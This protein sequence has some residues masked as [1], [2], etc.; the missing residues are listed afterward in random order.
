ML[1]IIWIFRE[2]ADV[3]YALNNEAKYQFM[4]E[5]RNV[6]SAKENNSALL[7]STVLEDQD[8]TILLD[9]E[10]ANSTDKEETQAESY[11]TVCEPTDSLNESITQL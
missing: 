9:A 6:T 11:L 1:D 4:K 8:K 10:S 2:M 3:S 5:S 7:S